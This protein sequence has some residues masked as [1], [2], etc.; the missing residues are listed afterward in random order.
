MGVFDRFSRGRSTATNGGQAASP[1]PHVPLDGSTVRITFQELVANQRADASDGERAYYLVVLE[2]VARG[3]SIRLGPEPVAIGRTAPANLVLTDSRVSRS[4]C[5]VLVVAGQVLVT[6]RGS[7]NGS[8][9]DG[10]RVTGTVSLRL[11]GTLQVGDHLLTVNLWN[12]RELEEWTRLAAR[13]DEA[14]VSAE[15]HIDIDEGQRQQEVQQITS[16]QYF[17]G[18]AAEID[19][20]RASEDEL[21]R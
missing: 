1:Q 17:R 8:F 19:S 11:G 5:E 7:T 16:S 9:V 15:I 21:T 12:G 13:E 6:D 14:L 3:Q 18:L 4:H 20:L 10:T 2:G